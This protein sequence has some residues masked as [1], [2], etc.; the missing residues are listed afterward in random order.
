M[1]SSKLVKIVAVAGASLLSQ[2]SAWAQDPPPEGSDG[3][4]IKDIKDLDDINDIHDIREVSLEALLNS[5]IDVATL[6]AQTTRETAGIVTVITREE[7]VNSGARDIVDVLAMVPGFSFG[8]DVQ[9]TVDIGVRGNWGHEGKTLLLVDGQEMNELLYSTN[10]LGDH[11]PVDQIQRVEIIR[12]PGS[13][14]YGGFAELA[15]INIITRGATDLNGVAASASYGQMERGLGHRTVSL[16]YGEKFKSGLSVAVSGYIGQGNRSDG[17]Y[18][19]FSGA[20][21]SSA[22]NSADAPMFVNAALGYKGLKLRFIFD[23]YTF[24]G[25]DGYGD[26][27]PTATVAQFRSFI[28]DAR[29]EL[30]L[31]DKLTVT[32]RVN[33]RHQTPWNFTTDPDSDV[34]FDISVMRTLGSVTASYDPVK[35]LNLLG[36]GETYYDYAKLNDMRLMGGQIPFGNKPNVSYENVSGFFQALYNS[37]LANFTAGARYEYHSQFGASFVPRAAIT[38]VKGAFHAK[39]LA[40][41]AFRA[42][43]IENINL[44]DKIKP[45]RT[46]VFEAEAG[47]KLT[48][49]LFVAANAYDITIRQPIVYDYDPV[50]NAEIYLNGDKTGTRGVEAEAK[51]RY[52]RGYASANYSYYSAA[53]KNNVPVYQVPTDDSVMLAFPSHKLTVNGNVNLW[54]TL[55]LNA[56]AIGFS[57]RWGYTSGDAAGNPVLGQVDDALLVNAYLMY[58]DLGWKGL[59]VGVGGFNLLGQ[60]VPYLQPYNGGHAPL[61]GASRDLVARVSYTLGFE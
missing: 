6:K 40:S 5:E 45:E 46:T 52:P 55:S 3:T 14:I 31:S 22:N 51:V 21:F 20:T 39:L 24:G 53:D 1:R 30:K 37:K 29:Y 26:V 33:F 9:G 38:K 15:V 18:T 4:D 49:H 16:S 61:P 27:Q 47:Y 59:D 36:G 25:Q 58:R 41:Q 32:P 60:K 56:S 23:D 19:D 43:G 34:F 12:G 7:I 44:N 50:M 13:A 8:V 48:E 28:A 10:A 42:P 54:R 35:G 2:A 17:V 11:Y 57:K